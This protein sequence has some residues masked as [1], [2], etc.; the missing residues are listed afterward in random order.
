MLSGRG[1]N[2]LSGF[3]RVIELRN[4]GRAGPLSGSDAAD[5]AVAELLCRRG[6]RIGG[7]AAPGSPFL[8]SS[9]EILLCGIESRRHLQVVSRD[10]D[11]RAAAPLTGCS[12]V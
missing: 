5:A 4:K 3:L 6:A 7:A 1:E 12:G 2:P 11:R 10:P 9:G 8:L